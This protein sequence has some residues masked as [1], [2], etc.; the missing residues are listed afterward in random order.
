MVK[1]LIIRGRM[2]GKNLYEIVAFVIKR[3]RYLVFFV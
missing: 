1:N 2:G 3:I